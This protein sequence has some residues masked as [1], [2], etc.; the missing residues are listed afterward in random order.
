MDPF[1]PWADWLTWL[2]SHDGRL[3]RRSR[4]GNETDSDLISTLPCGV[5]GNIV[6]VGDLRAMLAVRQVIDKVHQQHA[7]DLCWMT[8]DEI[9]KV[10]GLPVPDRNV[11]DK[12]AML[13]NCS[14]FIDQMCSEGGWLSYAELEAENSRLK[15][16]VANV[17]K[18]SM[19]DL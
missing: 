3:C 6:T 18:V 2:D 11:G 10:A 5:G 7:D 13:A 12:K 9:F 4:G 8:I 14:R 16:E 19:E 15:K 1:R 17:K